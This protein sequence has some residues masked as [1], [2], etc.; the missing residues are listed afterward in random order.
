MC[1]VLFLLVALLSCL[2]LTRFSHLRQTNLLAHIKMPSEN[3]SDRP[4]SNFCEPS[5]PHCSFGRALPCN[6]ALQSTNTSIMSD[7]ATSPPSSPHPIK[8]LTLPRECYE[9]AT[10]MPRSCHVSATI[11]LKSAMRPPRDFHETATRVPR[12]WH[13][14]A[15]RVPRSRPHTHMHR[16]RYKHTR[17]DC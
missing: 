1:P 14:S 17:T 12:S 3:L 10:R 16:N 15:T 7:T 9:G 5:V 13:E 2:L 8:K 11:M 6:S 4:T